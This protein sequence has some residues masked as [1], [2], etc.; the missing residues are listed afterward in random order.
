MPIFGSVYNS[1]W[2]GESNAVEKIYIEDSVTYPYLMFS[3][4]AIVM[5]EV[6]YLQLVMFY[7]LTI[8][9]K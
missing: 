3:K 1:I 5:S 4:S 7:L 8:T 9:A 6:A 2:N